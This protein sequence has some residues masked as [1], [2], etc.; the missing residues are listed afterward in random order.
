MDD[1]TVRQLKGA[2]KM[3]V[4]A[5]QVVSGIA[6]ATGHGVLGG[7][8]RSHQMTGHA[9]RLGSLSVKAGAK[10]IQEGYSDLNR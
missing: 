10:R 4:G 6:T 7:I 1:R 8:L 5:A 9:V 3:A 2:G